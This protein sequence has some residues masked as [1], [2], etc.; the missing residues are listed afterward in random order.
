MR[1]LTITDIRLSFSDERLLFVARS[2][3]KDLNHMSQQ[4]HAET[5]QT[6]GPQLH[7][8]GCHCGAVRYEVMIDAGRGGRCNCSICTKVSQLGGM[9]KPDAFR[10]LA[11]SELISVYQWGQATSR[12]SFCRQ[13]G[14]HCFGN[15]HLAELGGAFVSVN[16]N[17]LDTVDPAQVNVIYWDGRH[18]NWHAGPSNRP[19]PIT[20][21]TASDTGES[22]AAE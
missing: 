18:D 7:T 6:S 1:V 8:G 15:G 14:V 3:R 2:H 5:S 10:L 9:V 17:T 12:R 11:G 19:W 16:L 13:C 22:D 4:K 20:P 21:R